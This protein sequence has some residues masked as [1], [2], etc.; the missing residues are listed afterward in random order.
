MV[1]SKLWTGTNAKLGSLTRLAIGAAAPKRRTQLAILMGQIQNWLREIRGLHYTP[2][3]D[4]SF[5][6]D[7]S[8]DGVQQLG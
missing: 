6:L 2:H 8:A 7:E 1:F 3:F 5:F 4:S